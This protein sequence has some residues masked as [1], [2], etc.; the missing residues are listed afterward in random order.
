MIVSWVCVCFKLFESFSLDF[1][2]IFIIK[3][4]FQWYH[5]CCILIFVSGHA[6]T[7]IVL[8][9]QQI[10]LKR[11]VIFYRIIWQTILL[12]KI[13]L[14]SKAS[15]WSLFD[16][17][18]WF[19]VSLNKLRVVTWDENHQ[20]CPWLIGLDKSNMLTPLLSTLLPS[21]NLWALWVA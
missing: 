16:W 9:R 10:R 12:E 4:G 21:C 18:L 14:L 13:L 11:K 2:C 20:Q 5:L 8:L 6:K 17:Q 1:C 3:V 15:L 7:H 19:N